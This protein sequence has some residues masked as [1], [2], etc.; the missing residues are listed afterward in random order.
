MVALL[1]IGAGIQIGSGIGIGPD[2]PASAPSFTVTS[3]ELSS[4][5]IKGSSY[6]SYSTAGFTTDPGGYVYREIQYTMTSELEAAIAAAFGAGGLDV[7]YGYA[8]NV[9]WQTGGSG[10]IRVAINGF[11]PNTLIL[12]PIDTTDTQWQ[13]GSINGPLQVGTFAFPATFTLYQPATAMQTND[14]WC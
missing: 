12:S 11:G 14:S 9:S 5:V 7:N 13:S 4:P 1:Q 2:F 3:A 8:W 6:S 10:I